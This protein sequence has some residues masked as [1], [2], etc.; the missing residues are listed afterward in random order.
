MCSTHGVAISAGWSVTTAARYRQKIRVGGGV[1]CLPIDVLAHIDI[2]ECEGQQR[3][4]EDSI[5]PTGPPCWSS[6]DWHL[7]SVVVCARRRASRDRAGDKTKA[8]YRKLRPCRICKT[9]LPSTS[10]C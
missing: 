4:M 10:L 1:L 7:A 6:K 5:R 8:E 3:I 2:G 9:R